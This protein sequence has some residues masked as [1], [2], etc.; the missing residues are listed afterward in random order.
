MLFARLLAPVPNRPGMLTMDCIAKTFRY[1]DPAE[2]MA[3]KKASEAA[4]KAAKGG[5]P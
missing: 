2:I 5:K 1:L 4:A 3:Q